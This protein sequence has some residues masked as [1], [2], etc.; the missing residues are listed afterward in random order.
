MVVLLGIK[1]IPYCVKKPGQ[2]CPCT[3]IL[4]SINQTI[5]H[6]LP[7]RAQRRLGWIL[8]GLLK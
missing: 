3:S 2:L 5:H 1:L 7:R 8:N 4:I 6:R